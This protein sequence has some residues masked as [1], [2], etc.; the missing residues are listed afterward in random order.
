M[1]QCCRQPERISRT[2]G[3]DMGVYVDDRTDEQRR[4]HL[5]AVVGT[6]PGMSGWGEA[7]DGASYAGWACTYNEWERCFDMVQHR[8]DMKYVRLVTLNKYHPN[9]AHTHIYV[10][11]PAIHG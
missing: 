7:A 1:A 10:Y 8:C 11:R 3:T 9:A 2:G 4:T 5:L 6:D